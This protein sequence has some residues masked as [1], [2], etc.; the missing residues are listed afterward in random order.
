LNQQI[1]ATALAFM[2]FVLA[3]PASAAVVSYT[4]RAAFEATLSSST[5]LDLETGTPGDYGTAGGVTI[6]GVTFTG[7]GQSGFYLFLQ[8]DCMFFANLC[9]IGP[10]STDPTYG[11]TRI[12]LPAGVNSIGADFAGYQ[13]LVAPY[14]VR[15]STGDTVTGTFSGAFFAFDFIGITSTTPIAYADFYIGFSAANNNQAQASLI[16][17]VTFGTTVP[18]PSTWLLCLPLGILAI[19]NRVFHR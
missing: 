3:Y 12:T 4:N 5:T 18:E 6:G 17:N 16:D 2:A 14:E 19:R 9:I 1:R 8:D 13:G 7:V 15:L 11:Y 10:A